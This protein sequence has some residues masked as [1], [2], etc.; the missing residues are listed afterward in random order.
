M[1]TGALAVRRERP[2]R[3]LPCLTPYVQVAE[4]YVFLM[5]T[6]VRAVFCCGAPPYLW[7]DFHESGRLHGQSQVVVGSVP[8]RP[9]PTQRAETAAN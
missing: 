1:S 5:V 6:V 8:P 2:R 3:L 9:H 7:C 4:L